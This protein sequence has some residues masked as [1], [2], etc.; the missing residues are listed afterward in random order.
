MSQQAMKLNLGPVQLVALGSCLP[1]IGFQFFDTQASA[2]EVVKEPGNVRRASIQTKGEVERLVTRSR[3]RRVKTKIRV[4]FPFG[5]LKST[6]GVVGSQ[7]V[8]SDKDEF[9]L[10]SEERRTVIAKWHSLKDREKYWRDIGLG[11]KH[12]HVLPTS[13][14]IDRLEANIWEQWR[15][16]P[17]SGDERM[18]RNGR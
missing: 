15:A 18:A 8:L 2:A 14:K 5:D 7:F 11:P 6:R 17:R 1:G 16:D 10:E 4:D 13:E 9:I 3:R 12:P